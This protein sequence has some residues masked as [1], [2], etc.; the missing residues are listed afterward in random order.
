MR[1]PA[2]RFFSLALALI[3]VL[4]MIPVSAQAA[5][6]KT[7][8]F[9]NN[10]LWTDV[11]IHYWGGS[12]STEWP[13]VKMTLV[14]NDGTYDIYKAEVPAD[15]TG[16]QFNGIKNDGSGS[17]DQT[18]DITDIQTGVYYY[19]VWNN[20]NAVATKAYTEPGGDVTDPSTEPSSS[21]PDTTP[22]TP[23]GD[24]KVIYFTNTDNW[25]TVNAYYWNAGGEITW[26]GLPMTKVEDNIYSIVVPAGMKY[27]IFNNGS[28]QTGNIDLPTDNKNMYT[29]STSSWS[30]YSV[31]NHSWD[32]GTVTTDPTCTKDGVKTYTCSLCGETKTETVAAL[33]HKYTDG[34]CSVCGECNHSW[35]EGNVTTD[36]TCTASGVKTYTCSLCGGTKTET[37]AA[38]GHNMENGSCTRCG[39]SDN[40]DHFWRLPVTVSPTCEKEG[41]YTETCLFCQ[42]K[43]TEVLPARG[44][45]YTAGRC[46]YCGK[47]QENIQFVDISTAAELLAFAN[48]VNAGETALN[49]RLT[50]DIDLKSATWTP[51]G[52]Y[53]G[54]SN[55]SVYYMGLFEGNGHTISNFTVVGNDSVGLFGYA[56]M[57]VIQ[58]LGVVNATAT[59]W[60]AGAIAGYA[61]TSTI[62]N[63][64]AKDCKIT[65]STTN[66]VAVSSRA[67]HIGAVAGANG[68]TVKN[69]YAINCT[70][71]DNTGS[72]TVPSDYPDDYV[73]EDGTLIIVPPYYTCNVDPVGGTIRSNNYYCNISGDFT[74]TNGATE[75]TAAQMAS[76][77]VTY[78]LN[79]GVTS[80]TQ[81][82][83]QTCGQGLPAFSGKTVYETANGTYVNEAVACS[84]NWSAATCTAPK[85]CSKCG[86]TEG[87][88]LGHSWGDA[89]CTAPKT[90]SVCGT[91]EGKELGHNYVDG[92]CTACGAADPDYVK[93]IEKFDI[94]F[95]QIDMGNALGMNFAFPA[96][97]D[98]D[99]T[100]AYAEATMAGSTQT[101]P[102]DKWTTAS[103]GGAGHYVFGY[104]NI[105]AKQMAD[106]ITIVIYNADGEAISNEYV[107]SIQSY[108]MRNVDKKD[109]ESKALMVDM[110]NYGAAAQVYYGYN[111]EDL[112]N[113]QLSDAQKA[114][115]TAEL[116]E[117]TDGRVK[118]ANYLGTRLELG[119]SIGMQMNFAGTTADMYAVIEFT[120]HGGTEISERVAPTEIDGVYLINIT[121]I[122]VADGRI[123]VTVTVYNADG[124]VYGTA[125]DSMAS[126]IA[127]MSNAD[128]LYECIMKFS[129]SAY[130]YL[131]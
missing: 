52:K 61:P 88:E 101:I 25:S 15:S 96:V 33:G 72:M 102:A 70:L 48:R 38:L 90:C 54:D 109:A 121:Q 35:D 106:E 20:T 91:T 10:W 113:A 126:Y 8:Y 99:F 3:L 29:Y 94:A 92:A 19:M 4:S 128:A 115:G 123:P 41:S 7:V 84:H 43:R 47:E 103:I 56:E 83:Y 79:N 42:A 108:V 129:D 45:K 68:G 107:D 122:A 114:Y 34:K 9:Q 100:G 125:T 49:G 105:A 71:I 65:G 14:E 111:A 40:C 110:L 17:R 117:I 6:T 74:A 66:S 131:H 62:E 75:A 1:K 116:T 86:E 130:A 5:N 36:P 21:E 32:K 78:K 81:A 51:I 76:G 30:T 118:G 24:D 50:A 120:N 95:A 16:I 13:G 39:E 63:C 28:T 46:Y 11:S 73:A 53:N 31:C 112:A 18:P 59:G 26:P 82:W 2:S 69:C 93:P 77:E 85:T 98:I 97:E 64:F 67:V 127:R 87:K 119:S 104:S 57:A 12:S 80:G 60:N 55:A 22:T 58:N 124:N 44:H 89:T 27:I 23:S 37:V